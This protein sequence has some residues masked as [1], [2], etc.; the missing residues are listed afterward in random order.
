MDQFT[1][2]ERATDW[3]GNNNIAESIFAQMDHEPDPVPAWIVCGAG[4]GG[5]SATLGRYLRY[6]RHDSRLCVADP[7]GS[8]FH[9]H[10]ADRSIVEIDGCDS[11]IQG[12][13]RPCVEASFIATT[14]DRMIAVPDTASV[15]A[16][17]VISDVI[18][19][20]CG[21]STGTNVWACARLI[22]EMMRE[23]RRGSIV[24]LLCDS[25]DRYRSTLFDDRWLASRGIDVARDRE[26]MVRFFATGRPID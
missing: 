8:V 16:M 7:S 22:G 14:I 9:R 10:F 23:G 24:T 12:I 13:G 15:A 4:T 18:G 20:P 1:F 17:R 25:G 19:K 6:R 21:G 3:R 11:L 26:R 5:T 2:A